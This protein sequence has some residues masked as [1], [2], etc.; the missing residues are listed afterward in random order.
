[1]RDAIMKRII[2]ERLPLNL[3]PYELLTIF[4]ALCR[5]GRRGRKLIKSY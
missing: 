5:L 2:N 3:K 1:M 4:E